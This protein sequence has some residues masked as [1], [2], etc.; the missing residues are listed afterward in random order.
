MFFN[1]LLNLVLLCKDMELRYGRIRTGGFFSTVR[2]VSFTTLR[3]LS[4]IFLKHLF[5]KLSGKSFFE[6]ISFMQ[7][8]SLCN[9][10]QPE[11]ICKH[12]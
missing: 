11:Q 8:N 7:T 9:L 1:N 6:K 4:I 3:L 5:I 10:V 2:V 12:L